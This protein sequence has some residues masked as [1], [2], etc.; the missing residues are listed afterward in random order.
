MEQRHLK[1]EMFGHG[2]LCLRS[3]Y[4]L[5]DH[6]YPTVLHVSPCSLTIACMIEFST[7]CKPRR[8]RAYT[9]YK[10][11]TDSSLPI[12]KINSLG[13]P[14]TSLSGLSTRKALSAFTSNH[15]VVHDAITVLRSLKIAKAIQFPSIMKIVTKIEKFR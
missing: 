14:D 15:D 13:T 2:F 6:P 1:S 7:T 8:G 12:E 4:R 9:V 3:P 5:L 10:R 11:T